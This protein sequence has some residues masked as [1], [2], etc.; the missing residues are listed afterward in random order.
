MCTGFDVI[1]WWASIG[2]VACYWYMGKDSLAQEHY[3]SID[4]ISGDRYGMGVWHIEGIW[5][6][7]AFLLVPSYSVSAKTNNV[8]IR[9]GVSAG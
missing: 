7:S 3:A 8:A 2:L 1:E 9:T 5:T 6:C 4:G